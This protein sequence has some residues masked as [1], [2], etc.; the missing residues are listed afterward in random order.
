MRRLLAFYLG[1]SD[2]VLIGAIVKTASFC[3]IMLIPLGIIFLGLA[4]ELLHLPWHLS[5]SCEPWGLGG[6]CARLE[7]LINKLL[8][9][10]K[11]VAVGL[12]FVPFLYGYMKR[13]FILVWLGLQLVNKLLSSL[14]LI[15]SSSLFIRW[16]QSMGDMEKSTFVS[17][18]ADGILVGDASMVG[19]IIIM[20][21][22]LMLAHGVQNRAL[23][24]ER[25]K[26]PEQ[27]I[28]DMMNAFRLQLIEVLRK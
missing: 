13:S 17:S 24:N 12:A 7:L 1:L 16:L 27:E 9:Y 14:L 25:L 8:L 15:Y 5:W 11:V 18:K 2:R 19:W 10:G 22:L 6:L 3:L 21:F 28:A 23:K 4:G 20:W 26:K